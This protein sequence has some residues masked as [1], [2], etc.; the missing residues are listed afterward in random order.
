MLASA[1]DPRLLAMAM[2]EELWVERSVLTEETSFLSAD[3][4]RLLA[5]VGEA[6]VRIFDTSCA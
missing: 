5:K 6:V 2:E 3:H 4:R 1:C